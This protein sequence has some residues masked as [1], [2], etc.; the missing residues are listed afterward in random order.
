MLDLTTCS[1]SGTDLLR[2]VIEEIVQVSP[3]IVPADIMVVGASCRDVLHAALGHRHPLRGTNDIDIALALPDW[4]AFDELIGNLSQVPGSGNGIRYLVAGLVVDLMPFG[5]I[6]NPKGN[7]TPPPRTEAFSVWAFAEVFAN[8]LQLPLNEALSVRIPSIPGYTALKL[9]AWLDRSAYQETKDAADLATALY[10][11]T[12]SSFVQER[13]YGSEPGIAVLIDVEMDVSLACGRL[14]GSD[15]AELLGSDR[16]LELQAR[17][18]GERRDLLVR[19]FTPLSIASWPN[20][21]E[22]RDSLLLAIEQGLFE[23][24]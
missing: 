3:R 2:S 8:A 10:W 14:L 15:V 6:E 18:P 17:W 9:C 21:L 1:P 4:T 24:T 12:E 22:R 23:Q 5:G 13:L 7:V 20:D 19:E 11:Y 16:L